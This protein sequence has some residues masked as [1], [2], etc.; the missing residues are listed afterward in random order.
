MKAK[1]QFLFPFLFIGLAVADHVVG[2][3]RPNE[4]MQRDSEIEVIL[5]G[6]IVFTP[7]YPGSG[8][9]ESLGVPLVSVQYER[10]FLG[11][12]PGSPGPGGLGMY[13]NESELLQLGVALSH[14]IEY[15]RTD[16]DVGQLNEQGRIKASTHGTLFL[17]L[18]KERCSLSASFSTDLGGNAQG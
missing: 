16:S 12:A 9:L 4:V 3:E 15:P 7:K 6:G 11:G 2:Q 10:Y 5:G 1:L 8:D 14:D 17:S 13:L 18:E